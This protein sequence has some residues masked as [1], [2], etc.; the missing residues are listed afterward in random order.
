MSRSQITEHFARFPRNG[1]RGS[2]SFARLSIEESRAQLKQ[3]AEAC[4]AW[5]RY[6]WQRWLP[7]LCFDVVQAQ[8][9]VARAVWP[10]PVD[11]HKEIPLS[12]AQAQVVVGLAPPPSEDGKLRA[13]PLPLPL[14]TIYKSKGDPQRVVLESKVLGKVSRVS[15]ATPQDLATALGRRIG[16]ASLLRL[17][18]HVPVGAYDVVQNVRYALTF[19]GLRHAPRISLLS[20]IH[21]CRWG[22]SHGAEQRPV[23]A[24]I[25]VRHQSNSCA[26]T[27]AVT[28]SHQVS[29]F[30][31][32]TKSALGFC[33]TFLEK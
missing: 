1:L 15:V 17:E 9:V 5:C 28:F 12:S 33:F 8:H 23:V 26:P 10:R 29:H 25:E 13:V 24:N 18:I 2:E 20:S 32:P 31:Y 3:S 16:D 30:S 27:K 19:A 11:P 21:C 14:L 4:K 7:S 6:E 22:R